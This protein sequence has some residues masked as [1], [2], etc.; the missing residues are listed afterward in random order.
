LPFT[1]FNIPKGNKFAQRKWRVKTSENPDDA[2]HVNDSYYNADLGVIVTASM[3]SKDDG[4]PKDAPEKNPASEITWKSWAEVA[5]ETKIENLEFNF[6]VNIKNW[7]TESVIIEAYKRQGPPLDALAT[8][9]FSMSGRKEEQEAFLALLGTDNTR[10]IEY[11][12]K[13]HFTQVGQKKIQKI[14]VYPF[15]RDEMKPVEIGWN[16]VLEIGR[17][18]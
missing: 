11:M 16:M 12:L 15:Q 8:G 17:D 13:D 10:P 1:D 14:W 3:Y 18:T 4:W 6:Q 5:G 7:G 2:A 9:S